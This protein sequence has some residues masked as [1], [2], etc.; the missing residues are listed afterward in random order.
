MQYMDQQKPCKSVVSDN[1]NQIV[2]GSDQRTGSNCGSILILW[3]NIGIRVPTMLE[4]TMAT[5]REKPTQSEIRKACPI[6]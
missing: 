6:G 3:K 1:G 5:I 2:D 4:I